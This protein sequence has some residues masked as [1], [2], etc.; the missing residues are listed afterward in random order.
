MVA[1]F[2]SF[3]MKLCSDVGILNWLKWCTRE[4]FNFQMV[5]VS[6]IKSFDFGRYGMC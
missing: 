3:V 4:G 6:K 2:V 5:D 1:Y